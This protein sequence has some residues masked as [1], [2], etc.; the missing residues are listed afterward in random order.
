MNF[1][2]KNG[3]REMMR[4]EDLEEIAVRGVTSAGCRIQ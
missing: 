2:D 4:P 3:K 1:R